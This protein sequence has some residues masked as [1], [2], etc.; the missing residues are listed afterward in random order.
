[1]ARGL[2]DVELLLLLPGLGV[3]DC[4]AVGAADEV[5]VAEGAGCHGSEPLLYC[6]RMMSAACSARA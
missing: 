2:N 1:M 6:A 4:E 3:E 5:L